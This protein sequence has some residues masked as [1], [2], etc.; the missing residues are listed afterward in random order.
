MQQTAQGNLSA[1]M[2]SLRTLTTGRGNTVTAHAAIRLKRAPVRSSA[3]RIAERVL[4]LP[5][6]Y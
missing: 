5:K 4:G 3:T 2:V 1:R 6:S